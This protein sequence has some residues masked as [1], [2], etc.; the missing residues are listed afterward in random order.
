MFQ[1]KWLWKHL[2]ECRIR[3]ILALCCTVV[4]AM[5]PLVQNTIIANIVD[6]VFEP[7]RDMNVVPAE[8]HELLLSMSKT[9]I[10]FTLIRTTCSYT[11]NLT[12]ERCSQTFV[13][14]M[15]RSLYTNLQ[16]QDMRFYSKNRTGDLMTRLTG[17][18]EILRHS[19]A[20]VFRMLI[21][22]SVL[23]LSTTISFYYHDV[24]MANC[25]LVVTPF[26]FIIMI[27]F[28]RNVRPLY[29]ELR[30]KLSGMNTVA[31]ENISG[32]KVVKAFAREDFEREKFDKSNLEYKKAST[33][34][35]TLWLKY[36]PFIDILSQSLAVAVLLVGGSFLISGRITIGTF[37]FFNGLAFS[38]TAPIKTIGVVLNDL[39]RFFASSTKI[40]ELYYARSIIAT[41]DDAYIDNKRIKG[42]VE[43][44]NISLIL[45]S[46]EILSDISFSIKSGETVAIM[47]PTGC[48]KTS[49]LNLIPRLIDPTYGKIYIDGHDVHMFDLK[50][51]RNS[52][53]MANQDVFL[54]SETVDGNIAYGDP[55]LS[56]SAV[57]RYATDASVDFIEKLP[58]G[59]ETIIG[60]RGTGLSGGQKQRIAL[61]RALAFQPSILILDDTTSAVDLETEAHIQKSLRNLDYEC[62][63]I[64]IAQRIS[65]TKTADKVV[66]MDKGRIV[67][68]GTHDELIKVE[69]YYRD[70]FL[71]QN[72]EDD[73]NERGDTN[74]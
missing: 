29:V 4:L 74:G 41:R 63:K 6:K 73:S 39:Q 22:A 34:A 54:F 60:E 40:I 62:T 55:D 71:L 1:L 46:T 38:L 47:G 23:F 32:N 64:I 21:E 70:V 24:F 45:N 58:D 49:L 25:L 31:Q 37:T 67:Q 35:S 33:T 8:T 50:A 5:A 53:G 16:S 65:T 61:A 36:L 10:L 26:I 72:G 13:Y 14:N 68:T 3:Y 57:A 28:S 51:L 56:E 12:F 7:L 27:T 48:G 20:W 2:Q 42:D 18:M 30:E 15:R 11:L 66:I 59:F 44:E 69:G 19:V 43:F 9:L 17:D 52:I